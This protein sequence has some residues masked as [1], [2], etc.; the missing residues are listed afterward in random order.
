MGSWLSSSSNSLSNSSDSS[1]NSLSNSSNW[2]ESAISNS[3]NWTKN[4]TNP[5]SNS[6]YIYSDYDG[7]DKVPDD[8]LNEHLEESFNSVEEKIKKYFKTLKPQEILVT[9]K[10]IEKDYGVSF[11][12]FT[13]ILSDET[14]FI[15]YF[16]FSPF[17]KNIL[18]KKLMKL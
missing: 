4:P 2:T 14:K 12:E 16:F 6:Q 8:N 11:N 7:K 10:I 15:N 3:L 5:K 17:K 1:K 13:K 18:W 9:K